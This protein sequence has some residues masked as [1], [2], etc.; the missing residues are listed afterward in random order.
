MSEKMNTPATVLVTGGSGY[1]ASWIVRY[2]LEEGHL[3]HTTIRRKSDQ[4]KYA[5]LD[6]LSDQYP[7]KLKFF[8]A[9]LMKA[10]S[11][12]E[13]TAGC[14]VVIHAASPFKITGVKDPQRELIGPAVEGVRNVFASI[15]KAGTVR[16]VVL[17]SS[18]AAIYGNAIE[19]ESIDGKTFTE[20][21]WNS[22]SSLTDLP[23]SYSKTLAEKEAWKLTGD[24]PGVDLVV[25]NPGFILGPSLSK[26]TDSTSIKLMRQLT[27]GFFRLGVPRG[28]QAVVDVRDAALAHVRA[29]FTPQAHGRHIAAPHSRDFLE[30]A[31]VIHAQYPR[32]PLPSGYMPTWIFYIVGPIAGYSPSFIRKNFGYDL[33]FDNSRISK[34]LGIRFR[35]WKETILDHVEQLRNDGLLKE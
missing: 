17:T 9:D 18:I 23:Y 10:G 24:L 19:S 35:P 15:R 33:R 25:I 27:S 16:R 13:A 31:R 21:H 12:D 29:A 3:V 1:L 26:R 22:T 4:K 11:F 30:I 32:L 7:G 20:E 5:H 2:L 14:S 34:E 8:E 28:T 6:T